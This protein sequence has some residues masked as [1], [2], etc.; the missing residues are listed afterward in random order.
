[1]EIFTDGYNLD[2][3]VGEGIFSESLGVSRSTRLANYCSILQADVSTIQTA[4]E[5]MQSMHVPNANI[6][7]LSNS[8]TAITACGSAIL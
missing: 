2:G 6:T 4:A 8:K 3:V 1:M 5:T 7:I